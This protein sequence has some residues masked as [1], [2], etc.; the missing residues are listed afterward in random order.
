MF[1]V[2]EMATQACYQSKTFYTRNT[3]D[4]LNGIHVNCSFEVSSYSGQAVFHIFIQ[5]LF[6]SNGTD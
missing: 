3:Q 5:T 1:S 2:T 4:N 6:Y